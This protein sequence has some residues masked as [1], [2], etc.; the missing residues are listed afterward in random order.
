MNPNQIYSAS[1][2]FLKNMVITHYKIMKKIKNIYILELNQ[3]ENLI[4][5]VTNNN[6]IFI[7]DVVTKHVIPSIPL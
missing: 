5:L 3:Y 4:A 2:K 1:N 7:I 6:K